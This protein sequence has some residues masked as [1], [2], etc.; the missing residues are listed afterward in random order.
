MIAADAAGTL[1][2]STP[3]AASLLRLAGDTA[4]APHSIRTWLHQPGASGAQRA[5]ESGLRLE[6]SL[7]GRIGPDE[8]LLRVVELD[9]VRDG[10]MLRLRM[11]LTPREGEVLLWLARGKSNRD[12]AEVLDLSPRTVNKH[13]EQ[14]YEMLGVENRA[15]AVAL[16]I[17][18][19]EAA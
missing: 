17:R 15:S 14:V 3:Q 13:L 8:I 18:G 12:I 2:W 5:V 9:D 4:A 19:L 10:Q 11:K 7:I 1:R 16:A 6:F